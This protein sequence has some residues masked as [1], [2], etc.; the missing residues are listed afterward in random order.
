MIGDLLSHKW[1]EPPSGQSTGPRCPME[2]SPFMAQAHGR[3]RTILSKDSPS[4]APFHFKTS[5]SATMGGVTC[6]IVGYKVPFNSFN[7]YALSVGL[8]TDKG[9][10]AVTAHL[11]STLSTPVILVSVDTEISDDYMLCC[12]ADTTKPVYDCAEILAIEVEPAFERIPASIVTEGGLRRIVAN[13]A[14]VFHPMRRLD[15]GG[16]RDLVHVKRRHPYFFNL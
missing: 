1:Q 16:N 14:H 6:A 10:K 12:V 15:E 4:P 5:T 9:K 3:K 8:D 7:K 2:K 13:K 11:S